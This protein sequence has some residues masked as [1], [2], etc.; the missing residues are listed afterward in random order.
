M[1]AV[2][3]DKFGTKQDAILKLKNV[4]FIDKV[5]WKSDEYSFT[6]GWLAKDLMMATDND[7]SQFELYFSHKCAK[8]S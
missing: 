7:H 6:A 2:S 3:K 5:K 4:I 1:S 8:E